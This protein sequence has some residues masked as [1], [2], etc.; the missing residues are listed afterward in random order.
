[1][2][3]RPN[4]RD[5]E[6]YTSIYPDGDATNITAWEFLRR[7]PDYQKDTEEYRRELRKWCEENPKLLQET[8]GF[9]ELQD[10]LY[11]QITCFMETCRTRYEFWSDYFDASWGICFGETTD[12]DHWDFFTYK[13][14][15]SPELF[16]PVIF[17]QVEGPL[18]LIPVDLSTPLKT[19]LKMVEEEIRILR[20]RGIKDGT[21]VTR[22]NR[23]LENRVYIEQLR[24]LDAY[25]AGATVHEI[26]DVLSP[27]AINDAESKQ[28][29]KRIK[30][31]HQAALKMQNGGYRTLIPDL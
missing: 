8:E 5:P 17:G 28:R 7:N 1:M 12:D 18:V 21:V 16:K 9:L 4:W 2:F 19:L 3:I 20:D 24:I 11:I 10:D 29:D 25:A 14:W 23:V 31:V 6:P 26:G 27:G 30:A 22:K 15:Y 13:S